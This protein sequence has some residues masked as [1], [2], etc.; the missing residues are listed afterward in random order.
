MEKE[1]ESIWLVVF[2]N[3]DMYQPEISGFR[4]Q[5]Q[6]IKYFKKIVEDNLEEEITEDDLDLMAYEYNNGVVTMHKMKASGS[7]SEASIL[8]VR[9]LLTPESPDFSCEERAKF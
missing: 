2:D 8:N 9:S 1:R 3:Y 7:L 5:K 4:T 6:A